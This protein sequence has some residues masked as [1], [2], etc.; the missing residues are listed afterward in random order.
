[1]AVI[2]DNRQATQ[3]EY[4]SLWR[5]AALGGLEL[6]SA[7]FIHQTFAAHTHDTYA[8]GLIE[9]G[10]DRFDYRGQN[11]AAGAGAITIIHPGELH[12]GGPFNADGWHYRAFYPDVAYMQR[13]LEQIEAKPSAIPFF[14]EPVIYDAELFGHLY[15]MHAATRATTCIDGEVVTS[16]LERESRLMWAMAKL[17]Q[18]YGA[19]ERTDRAAQPERTAVRKIIDYLHS[20][21]SRNVT[22]AELSALTSL[23]EFYL[24][25]VFRNSVG[26]PP[27]AY[28]NQ[29]RVAQA[30]TLLMQGMPP[31]DVAA[32]TGFADQ[33][34]LTRRLKQLTGVTPGALRANDS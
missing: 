4:A 9:R 25:R 31:V 20:N 11:E 6:L 8:I 10:A 24:L 30:K 19:T 15:R 32:Q 34:H 28:Q 29:L 17:V 23:S 21:L 16:P 13:I 14:R 5:D 2:S 27:H 3:R 22:L 18:R 26:L 33:A 7:H 1:M 12:T